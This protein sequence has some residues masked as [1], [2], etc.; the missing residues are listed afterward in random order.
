MEAV[1]P[2]TGKPSVAMRLASAPP[3]KRRAIL[4]TLDEPELAGLKWDWE[5]N[6]RPEQKTPAGNWRYWIINCGRG[7]GKNRT[8]AEFV[9]QCIESGEYRHIALISDTAADVRDV[10]VNHPESGLLAVSSPNFYPTYQ[11][12]N[13]QMVW[14]NGA[15]ATCYSAEAPEL[16]RGPQ[17]DL[18]WC[19]ELAKWRNLHR[20]DPGGN[21]A[22]S[23]LQFGLRIG[24]NPRCLITTTPRPVPI[25]K[26]LLK[27]PHAVVTTG[28]SYENRSNLSP[29]WFEAIITEYE[30]TML[31][32]QELEAEIIED[33]EGALWTREVLERTRITD[34]TPEQVRDR[35]IRVVVAV[36]PGGSTQ[37]GASETGITG[38]GLRQDRHGVLLA[39]RSIRALPEVWAKA[40]VDLYDELRADCVVA[41]RNFGGDMVEHTIKTIRQNVHIKLVTASRGKQVRAEP[42][43]ALQAQGKIHH[44]GVY[45]ALEDQQCTWVPGERSPDRMDADVWGFTELMLGK[46][47][48]SRAVPE[49]VGTHRSY[50]KGPE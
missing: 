30:G 43:S 32:R 42:V 18:A 15:I 10:M 5:Y 13:R 9:R 28:S 22:W 40:A 11:P 7:W 19:D 1:L 39:D 49:L 46:A 38:N 36:D 12:T 35:C 26:A 27:N 17:H 4:S 34:Q 6:C 2:R 21:T 44:V 48:S 8:G 31:G 45:P 3:D 20:V 33:V 16:L 25:Y 23:S 14:P 50:W 41:E 29:E 24:L 37:T 47:P